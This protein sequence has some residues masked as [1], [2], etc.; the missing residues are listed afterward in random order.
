[1]TLVK[2]L[3][4]CFCYYKLQKRYFDFYRAEGDTRRYIFQY[5]NTDKRIRQPSLNITAILVNKVFYQ[6]WDIKHVCV[7]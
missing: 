5:K 4:S 2:N 3:I 6:Q 1:M 7:S